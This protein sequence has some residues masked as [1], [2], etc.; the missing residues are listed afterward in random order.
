MVAV[1]VPNLTVPVV[2]PKSF[3][4]M[5]TLTPVCA[6]VGPIE[7]ICGV[8]AFGAVYCQTLTVFAPRLKLTAGLFPPEPELTVSDEPLSV[9]VR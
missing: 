4:P 1:V 5:V 2:E 9:P 7:P 3:P 8:V 6:F